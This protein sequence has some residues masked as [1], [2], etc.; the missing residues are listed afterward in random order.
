LLFAGILC[1]DRCASYLKYHKGQGQFCWAHFK[2]NI[3]GIQKIAK[4]TEAER[5]CRDARALHGRLFRLWHRFR[6]RPGVRYGPITREQLIE[7]S[8]PREKKTPL[9]EHCAA[10][11]NGARSASAAAAPRV[12]SR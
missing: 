3:L 1:S 5:F 8:I 7:K 9:S 10:S 11:Y 6:D 2:R 4:T 12:K